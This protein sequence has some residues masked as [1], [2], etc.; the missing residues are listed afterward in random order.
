[1]SRWMPLAAVGVVVAR[2]TVVPV[3]AQRP[4]APPRAQTEG[5]ATVARSFYAFHFAHD[6]G[7]TEA[8]VRRRSRWLSPDLLAR[9]RAYFARPGRPDEVPAIDGDPF[10]ESQEY[11]AGFRVGDATVRGD[12]AL[13]P[14]T[15]TWPE[16]E[17]RAVTLVLT[18]GARGW[19]IADVRYASGPSLRE[20]LAEG[21]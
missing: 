14:V 5:P 4:D 9:C 2:L 16:A 3:S 6:M 17:A 1:M 20:L 15:M 7:F 13:V 21:P 10:T 12:T 11:P 8:S 18:R 19:L